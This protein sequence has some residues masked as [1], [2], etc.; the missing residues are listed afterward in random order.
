MSVIYNN[1][2]IIPI[3][4]PIQPTK[5]SDGRQSDKSI[6]FDAVLQQELSRQ[7]EVKFSKHAAERLQMRNI[8]LTKDDLNKL[9]EAVNKAAEKG[10]KET[11]I[12]MGNSAFIANVKNKMIITAA[13][14]DN[15][16]NNV[17]TNIDGAVII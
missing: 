6:S 16:K 8:H 7:S 5:P 10:V 2:P 11:L 1:K 9:N 17:F 3:G 4:K 13:T 14:E 12:I 15:L